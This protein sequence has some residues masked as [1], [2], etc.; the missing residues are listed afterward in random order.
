M[1]LRL[2]NTLHTPPRTPAKAAWQPHGGIG[3]RPGGLSRTIARDLHR[4]KA[5]PRCLHGNIDGLTE[6]FF[7]PLPAELSLLERIAGCKGDSS[8]F[9]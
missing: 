2:A 7:D 5:G 1:R 4:L 9:R 8:H 6:A 3:H